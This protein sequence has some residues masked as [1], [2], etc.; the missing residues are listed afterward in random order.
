MGL[1]M[2]IFNFSSDRA[3]EDLAR[4]LRDG[5]EPETNNYHRNAI[6]T[7]KWFDK[8]LEQLQSDG[9]DASA[10]TAELEINDLS[11]AR[12]QAKWLMEFVQ[13][14]LQR[15]YWTTTLT[16]STRLALDIFVNV[17]L[18]NHRVALSEPDIVK[19]T[20]VADLGEV[21]FAG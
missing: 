15:V 9:R 17:N 12:L 5:I 21:R 1:Q 2:G 8:Q 3:N 11:V 18:G 10:G 20:L 6:H 14:L 16:C 13:V 7:S 19:V 4:V